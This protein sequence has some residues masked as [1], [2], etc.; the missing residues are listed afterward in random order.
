MT[1]KLY[2]TLKWIALVALPAVET[3]IIGLFTLWGWPNGN[4]IA[5]TIALVDALLGALLGISSIKYNKSKSE[6]EENE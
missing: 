1:N 5:G 3:F 6:V 4:L 2:D